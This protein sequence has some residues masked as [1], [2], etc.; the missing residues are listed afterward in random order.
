MTD[1][2]YCYLHIRRLACIRQYLTIHYAAVLGAAI[3]ASKLDY[4][5][6]FLGSTTAANISRLQ[7]A[8]NCLVRAIYRLPRKVQTAPYLS[9]LHWLPIKER[10]N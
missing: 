8:Q 6:I 4:C 3:V 9:Q 1:D 10:I 5:N 7:R 2:V